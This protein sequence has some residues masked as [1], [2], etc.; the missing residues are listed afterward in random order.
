MNLNKSWTQNRRNTQK[1]VKRFGN[2]TDAW[3]VTTANLPIQ[4]CNTCC[5]WRN[6]SPC[7]LRI[8]LPSRRGQ[9]VARIA[10]RNDR[11]TSS[12]GQSVQTPDGRRSTCTQ[13]RFIKWVMMMIGD[14]ISLIF[15]KKLQ[16]RTCS[17][18]GS[19]SK[20]YRKRKRGRRVRRTLWLRC[21]L[22]NEALWRHQQVFR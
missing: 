13:N 1:R 19:C 8:D 10:A 21:A 22:N 2:T 3:R 7:F 11:Q 15:R 6:R 14:G 9:E 17:R 5:E 16:L 12:Q 20:S 18:C 4:T